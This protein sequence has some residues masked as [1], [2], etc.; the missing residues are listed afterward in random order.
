MCK[1]G[2]S[3][4]PSSVASKLRELGK[5]HDK[6]LLTWKKIS[7]QDHEIKRGTKMLKR[8]VDALTYLPELPSAAEFQAYA[9]EL[10]QQ[11]L[12]TAPTTCTSSFPLL[13]LDTAT[14]SS[15]TT[16]DTTCL[17][18]VCESDPRSILHNIGAELLDSGISHRGL[19]A[20]LDQLAHPPQSLET[21]TL[22]TGYQIVGDNC[23]LHINVRHMTNENKNKSFHWFNCVAFKDQVSG[24]H[25]P[26]VHESTLEDV[27]VS[28]FFPD[29]ED[30]N[31][32]KRD[33]MTLWSRVIVNHLTSFAF[34]RNSVIYHI[35]H[36]YS[37]VMKHP[38]QEVSVKILS[39]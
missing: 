35:P 12:L 11:Q 39:I 29:N 4:H 18:L 15:S 34:L 5:D 22:P 7:E 31:Q 6:D 17:N 21:V 9:E 20:S 37:N 14:Q 24:D 8:E 25:L 30:I 32:L 13:A 19:I 2:L 1:M 3:C 10:K 26:D 33:F 38:V 36:Q 23:D 28:A 27:P 16:L